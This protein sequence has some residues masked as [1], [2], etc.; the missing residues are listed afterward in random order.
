MTVPGNP[1]TPALRQILFYVGAI[2][3]AGALVGALANAMDWSSGLIYGVGLSVCT[4]I[5]TIALRGSLFASA[6][7]RSDE[8]HLKRHA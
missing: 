8:H 6:R 7:Q 5:V 3:F 2:V 1:S 4:A